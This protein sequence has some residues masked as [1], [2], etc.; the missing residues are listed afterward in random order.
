MRWLKITVLWLF[1]ATAVNIK[2]FLMQERPPIYPLNVIIYLHFKIELGE[3]TPPLDP[4]LGYVLQSAYVGS[5]SMHSL[6]IIAV[7]F[8]LSHGTDLPIDN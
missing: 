7:W 3:S 4:A 2:A 6:I 5:A 1:V 8:Y